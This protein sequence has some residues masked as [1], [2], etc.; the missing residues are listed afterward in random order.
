MK[1]VSIDIETTGLDPSVNDIVEIGAVI[2]DLLEQ[3]PIEDLPTFH[4]YIVKG[5]YATDAYCAYLHHA[6]FDRI[7]RRKEPDVADRFLFLHESEVMPAFVDWLLDNGIGTRGGRGTNNAGY[8]DVAE[9]PRFT[10][11]GKNFGAF[12]LQFLNNKLDF[13]NHVRCLH[14]SID[15]AMLY[16]NPVQDKE[17]PNMQKC[18]DRAGVSEVVSHTGLADALAVVKLIRNKYPKEI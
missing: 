11:A 2:D 1:Y 18:L 10:A 5:T 4:C 12:D 16:F 9:K 7:A 15:P 8:P 3:P 13:S 14:R 17:P 6:I